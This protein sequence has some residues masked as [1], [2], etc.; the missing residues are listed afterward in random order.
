MKILLYSFVII[1]FILLGLAIAGGVWIKNNTSLDFVNFFNSK[2][3][4]ELDK[5]AKGEIKDS[6]KELDYKIYE[7]ATKYN[8]EGDMLPDNIDN[9]IREKLKEEIKKELKE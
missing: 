3:E 6:A 2:G 1:L 5:D 9:T 4:V 8:P 7:E